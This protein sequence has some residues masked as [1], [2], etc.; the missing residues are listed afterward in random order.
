M[1]APEEERGQKLVF[2]GDA[3]V[4]KTCLISRFIMGTFDCNS[5]AT[6]GAS[7]ASKTINI[8]ELNKSLTFDVWD[9]AG[10]EK[11][12]SLTKIFF[13]GAKMA[14]LVYDITRKV[15]FDNLKNSQY[16]LLKE[17]GEP[18]IVIGIAGNKS[19]LYVDED[20]PEQEAREFA[21]SIDAVFNL[22]S[23]QSNTGVNELFEDLG[24]KF[25][26]LKSP[27]VESDEQNKKQK[28]EKKEEQKQEKE[29]SK[30]N[31]KIGKKDVAKEN[32]EHK[33]KKKFC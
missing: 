28:Q 16:P 30:R 19:D 14:I 9:T 21:K 25:L 31:I 33:K 11:Y 13:Q 7:Y 15:S 5:P 32:E 10:Q 29:E 26:C 18:D 12:K 24:K 27:K 4:G 3:G 22:T 8:P 6:A 20:V 2:I 17:H 1:S 23:A